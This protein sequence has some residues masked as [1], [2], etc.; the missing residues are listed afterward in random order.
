MTIKTTDA[1]VPERKYAVL[2][3]DFI[4]KANTVRYE[5]HILADEV[6][7]FPDYC[8][9][10]HEKL[11][12]ELKGKG[13]EGTAGWL[14]DKSENGKIHIYSDRKILQELESCCPGNSIAYFLNFLR[15]GCSL[16]T[17]DF[18]SN[19]FYALD[20]FNGEEDSA[21]FLSVLRSCESDIG[22]GQSYGEVKAFILA[23]ALHFICDDDVCVFCSDD[24]GARRGFTALAHIPCISILGVFLKLKLIG[25]TIEEV[26]PF[27]SSYSH[28]CTTKNNPE[29]L[30]KVWVYKSGSPKRVNVQMELLLE[31]IYAGKYVIRRDG[32]LQNTAIS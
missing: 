10:A 2:D 31:D 1:P 22:N 19:H 28:L 23:E 7:S 32:D 25:R 4:S 9:Y 29:S 16:I 17:A 3:T 15:K 20:E 12:H 26:R 6:L 27:F 5:N 18:Y 14:K 8:F 24:S 21:S 13:T 30:I 11:L